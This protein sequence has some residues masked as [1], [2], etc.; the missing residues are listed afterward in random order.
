M[1][2]VNVEQEV[3]EEVIVEEVQTKTEWWKG[4][5]I[6]AGGIAL[7]VVAKVLFDKA[8]GDDEDEDELYTEPRELAECSD[9]QEDEVDPMDDED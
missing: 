2:N 3:T 5:L 1:E 6:A 8:A 9:E 7:G 4:A